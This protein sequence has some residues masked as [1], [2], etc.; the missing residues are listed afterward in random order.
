MKNGVVHQCACGWC[1]Q[2]DD[3][4][5][6]ELHAELNAFLSTLD[7][8]TRL[9]F[10]GLESMNASYGGDQRLALITGVSATAIARM[11]WG[12]QQARLGKPGYMQTL[13]WDNA[14]RTT[15]NY[16]IK[17]QFRDR[18]QKGPSTSS[19]GVGRIPVSAV[20]APARVRQAT[21]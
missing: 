5:T 2:G 8:P 13:S 21:A 3:G 6:K 4:G 17:E 1:R 18:Q 16:S 20:A 15:L 19:T 11:R 7:E 14:P 10:L 12:I 9:Q